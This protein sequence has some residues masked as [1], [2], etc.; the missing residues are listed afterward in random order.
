MGDCVAV[1]LNNRID[2]FGNTINIASR[3]VE[4]AK[5]EEVV[6]SDSALSS[7]ELRDLIDDEDSRLKVHQTDVSLKGYEN[8]HFE[9]KRLVLRNSTLRLVV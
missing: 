4:E 1:S 2:F 7:R 3:L 6:I 5:S 8:V 9:A